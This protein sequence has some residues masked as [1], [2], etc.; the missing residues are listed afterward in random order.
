MSKLAIPAGRNRYLTPGHITF[1]R[2]AME[3]V[4]LRRCWE[5]VELDEDEFTPALAKATVAWIRE[6]TIAACMSAGHPE[7]VGLFRRDPALVKVSTLPSLEEFIAEFQDG[8]AFSESEMLEL[9]NERFGI[10]RSAERRSRLQ[11]RLRQAFDLLAKSVYRA[12][13]ASDPIGQWLAPHLAEHLQAVGMRT[14]AD[15]RAALNKRRTARWDEVPGIG[16]KWAAR[17]TRWMD[18]HV[19]VVK[20]EGGFFLISGASAEPTSPFAGLGLSRAQR[21]DDQVEV[22][23]ALPAPPSQKSAQVWS[24]YPATNNRLGANNDAD[25]IALWIGARAPDN[26]NTQRSYRRAAERL[27]L[28]CQL[29]RGVTFSQMLAQ[30]CIH[31]RAWLT[32]LGRKTPE[33]WSKAGWKLPA[34]RWLGR[35]GIPRESAD[36]SPFEGAMA[37]TSVAQDLT[38]LRSLFNFL[39]EGRV[40]DGN[41]WLLMGKGNFSAPFGARDNQFTSRSLTVAQRDY[42]LSGLDLDDEIDARLNLILWLGFGC[43]L[44]SSELLGLTFSSLKITPERWSLDVIG[45][46]DKL[47]SVPLSTPVK[48]ALLHY[49]SSI[50]ISL[51]YVIRASSGLDER[52][53]LQPILRTQRGRRA[54]GIDGRKVLSTPSSPM[55]YQSLHRILTGHFDAKAAALEAQDPISAGRLKEASAHW[56]RHSCAVQALKKVPLN[57]V[58]KLLGHASIAV[59]GRYVVEDDEA[60]AS[61]MEE[62]LAPN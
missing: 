23:P 30:D 56:L 36:W 50:G 57:G 45:K 17:L 6:T 54:R 5:Y 55:S 14:L 62:F 53:A 28:W 60:L 24:P 43:G 20:P 49:M 46:G 51:D 33:E 2:A 34:E 44:R 18:E 7:L 13:K 42:L 40:V 41:P 12:P 15:V 4:E 32:D 26:V 3:G 59:T 52:H 29:E 37:K 27:L 25:A 11:A 38:I 39:Q 21:S 8:D 31:Y 16:E 10:N 48:T 61:A 47:R 58:Q 1:F 19:I 35:R 9:Y 22:L